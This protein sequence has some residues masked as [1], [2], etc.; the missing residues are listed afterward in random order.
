MNRVSDSAGSGSHRFR[1]PVPVQVLVFPV[2][3]TKGVIFRTLDRFFSEPKHEVLR[4]LD[5][6]QARF[7]EPSKE[8]L[9]SPKQSFLPVCLGKD[10]VLRTFAQLRKIQVGQGRGFYEPETR[11]FLELGRGVR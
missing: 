7:L 1:L 10:W 8:V 3:E 9:R 6:K 4:T 2:K 5:Q 11:N